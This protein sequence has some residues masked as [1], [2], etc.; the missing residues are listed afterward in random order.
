M[1]WNVLLVAAAA[2]AAAQPSEPGPASAPPKLTGAQL[3][4]PKVAAAH[5]SEPPKVAAAQPSTIKTVITLPTATEISSVIASLETRH[6]GS[7][8]NMND[9]MSKELS[10][11]LDVL[12]QS[13]TPGPD[14]IKSM[15]KGS[16]KHFDAMRE[17]LTTSEKLFDNFQ[18]DIERER[19]M[20][21]RNKRAVFDVSRLGEAI[22]VPDSAWALPRDV[23]FSVPLSHAAALSASAELPLGMASLRVPN[24]KLLMV[25]L[26]DGARLDAAVASYAVDGVALPGAPTIVATDGRAA[27][28]ADHTCADITKPHDESNLLIDVVEGWV[29]TMLRRKRCVAAQAWG[30]DGAG[31]GT[32]RVRL[33]GKGDKEFLLH[34]L[35]DDGAVAAAAAAAAAETVNAGTLVYWVYPT[36]PKTALGPEL[37]Q[38]KINTQLS[39]AWSRPAGS[40]AISER[41]PAIPSVP[42]R[43]APAA[44]S[45]RKHIIASAPVLSAPA[46]IASAPVLSAPRTRVERPS[47]RKRT[48]SIT[49][50]AGS[51]RKR[52]AVVTREKRRLSKPNRYLL[53][54]WEQRAVAPVS[55]AVPAHHLRAIRPRCAFCDSGNVTKP[56]ET[57]RRA[58]RAYKPVETKRRAIRGLSIPEVAL[59]NDSGNVGKPVETKRRARHGLSVPE[60]ALD[61]DRSRVDMRQKLGR[62]R[63]AAGKKRRDAARGSMSD[64]HPL[65]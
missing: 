25:V 38:H 55:T 10:K 17:I 12:L 44:G 59:D 47:E 20:R 3:A 9:L 33:A 39:F 26:R 56:V 36:P 23:S 34:V 60:V 31:K 54:T 22:V 5:P 7:L 29:E 6:M 21:A 28:K 63:I 64:I 8:F 61:K 46:T 51:E 30:V 52:T 48:A 11:K 32:T 1:L 53:S 4:L 18:A 2:I 16:S 35:G 42:G 50:A 37:P 49:P 24:D 62:L 45:E 41:E 57:K 65:E 58:G 15:I 43:S 27:F 19:T 13:P 14:A 40:S